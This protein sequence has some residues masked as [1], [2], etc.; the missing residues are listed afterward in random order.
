MF[1]HK[2]VPYVEQQEQSDCGLCCLAMISRYYGKYVTLLD[3]QE[4]YQNSRDGI[5]LHTLKEIATSLDMDNKIYKVKSEDL[6]TCNLPVILH[7]KGH[8]FVVLESI[9][10]KQYT[11][12]DPAQ[13]RMTITQEE[14]TQHFSGFT[15]YLKPNQN[16]K[17]KKAKNLWI[18]YFKM[19]AS[20][21]KFV[22]SL[23]LFSILLQVLLLSTPI[24]TNY[25]IDSIITP[26]NFNL[27]NV[28]IIGMS[29]LIVFQLIF[30]LIRSR[31][32]VILRNHLDL[33]M[34]TRFI[35]HL[36]YMPY[37]FFQ[38]R[39]FGDLMFRANSN[40]MIR[41]TLSNQALS[42][43]LDSSLL[44]VFTIY[45]F[46]QSP[47]LAVMIT[48][49]GIIYFVIIF[50]A[51]KRLHQLSKEELSKRTKVQ[52][53][54]SEMLY[55]ILG[56]KMAGMESEMFKDWEK[57]YGDQLS[58]IKK[59]DYYAA[60]LETLIF[61]IGIT[62]PF[63][64]LGLG[65]IKV[66]NNS[67][68]LG[69]MIAF[70]TLTITY[71]TMLSSLAIACSE[72]SKM[73]AY[74]EKVV[75]VLDR[76]TELNGNIKLTELKGNIF[77][78]NLSFSYDSQSKNKILKNISLDIRSGEKVAIVGKSGSGKST[79]ANL[80]IGLYEPTEGEI[81]FDETSLTQLDKSSLRKKIGIVPQDIN[82]FNRSIIDNITTYRPE[83]TL[84]EVIE[85]A[86]LAKIDTD[87]AN[88]PMGYNTIISEFGT[89]FSG[90]QKQR[91]A[92]AR[93]LIGKPSILLLDEATSS[94]D[95][96]IEEEIDKVLSDLRCT[97][98]VIAHRLSTVKNADKIVVL[99]QGEIVEIG[100]HESLIQTEG[101]Y[102]NLINYYDKNAIVAN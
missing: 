96:I 88:L 62:A 47:S 44:F 73:T 13:G 92:L 12:V 82:L 72:F 55:G 5:S 81:Y 60:N 75:D 102:Y 18:P 93:A 23:L 8:H 46:F 86:K 65:T 90:G 100:N 4:S 7:W 50:M 25:T 67:M 36:L 57:Y 14:F 69:S 35:S 98:I 77:V 68:S 71:F 95:T 101:Y 52:W 56:V 42:G 17:Q 89:N 91:I 99:D 27:I 45:L 21:K 20:K 87:I 78:R 9:K 63:L 94:L 49:I 53:H 34:M 32:V 22:F 39:S 58:A 10:N 31:L 84:D 41:Q 30:T 64:V 54:Q 51:N 70:F 59:K 2:Y 33:V 61:T 40:I 37:S 24:L 3:I 80:L 83:S 66:L 1:I 76:P 19:L 38:R 6:V 48:L 29:I 79:L 11:I 85:S 16:F 97:R 26:R 15:M 74:L 43:I 28:L